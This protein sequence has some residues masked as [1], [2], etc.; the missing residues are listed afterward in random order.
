M[1]EVYGEKPKLFTGEWWPYFWMY[2]KWHTIGTLLALLMIVVTAVQCA[3]KEKY[4]V[5]VNYA[6]AGYIPE[7]VISEL[8]IKFEE[9]APDIDGNGEINVFLQQLNLSANE[10]NPEM[11][12]AL[13]V[14]HDIELS[15]NTSHLYIY[16]KEQAEVMIGRENSDDIYI[17]VDEWFDGEYDDSAVVKSGSGTPLAICLKG[18]GLFDELGIN[19]ENMYVTVKYCNEKDKDNIASYEGALEMARAMM[20]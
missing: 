17:P 8:E 15:E 10:A 20:Q 1:A 18:S 5:T 6:G 19:A 14:K 7:E 12:Y 11:A 16:D 3:T 2:Y 4:D 9:Y 13:Q